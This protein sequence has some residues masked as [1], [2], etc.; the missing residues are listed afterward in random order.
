M[1]SP[2]RIVGL[3]LLIG[4]LGW[5]IWETLWTPQPVPPL[6]A[7]TE[8]APPPITPPQQFAP[9]SDYH[10]T[11]ERPLFSSD[12]RPPGEAM[13][14]A[15][16]TADGAQPV[17]PGNTS[18]LS[19]SAIIEEHGKRSALLTVPGQ[20]VSTRVQEGESIGGW[21]LVKIAEDGVT[22]EANGKRE[23]LPL[24]SFGAATP[25]TAV[26]AGT[27]RPRPRSRPPHTRVFGGTANPEPPE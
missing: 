24:R 15:D 1:V 20:A 19:L 9:L 14:D 12:R 21:R 22:V 7:A 27:A 6:D 3:T 26:K 2:A 23:E 16:A 4:L 25:P 10:V 5:A 8:S 13:A 17:I 11:L 18:R